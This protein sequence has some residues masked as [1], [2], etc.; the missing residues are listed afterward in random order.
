MSRPLKARL[1]LAGYAQL[2]GGIKRQPGTIRQIAEGQGYGRDTCYRLIPELHAL[3]RLHIGGWLLEPRRACVAIYHYGPG[4][5]VPAPATRPSGRTV[6]AGRTLTPKQPSPEVI[7]FCSAL[8]ELEEPSSALELNKATGIHRD[9]LRRM[10]AALRAEGLIHRCR[11]MPRDNCGG[12][13]VAMYV[14][15]EGKDVAYPN[16][17]AMRTKTVRAWNERVKQADPFRQLHRALTA[18]ANQPNE[19]QA[20]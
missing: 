13:H 8:D 7:S 17:R 1:G 18:P 5:D 4:Q 14:I 3:G 20:A 16:R 11:W 15:G 12:R 6:L 19:A 2:L 10:L 9:T